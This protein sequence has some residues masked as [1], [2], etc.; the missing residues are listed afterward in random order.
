MSTL[1]YVF[2]YLNV[3]SEEICRLSEVPVRKKY[4]RITV[5]QI[6]VSG[7]VSIELCVAWKW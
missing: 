7:S 2:S 1:K 5:F 4:F 3:V 6:L